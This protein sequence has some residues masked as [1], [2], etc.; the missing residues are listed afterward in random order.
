[1]IAAVHYALR[2]TALLAK[3]HLE[4]IELSRSWKLMCAFFIT[5]TAPYKNTLDL[6]DIMLSFITP[7]VARIWLL[8]YHTLNACGE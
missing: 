2:F 3:D 4:S 8:I 6:I 1:M 5:L 7:C